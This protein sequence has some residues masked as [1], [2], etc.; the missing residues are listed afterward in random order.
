MLV[1]RLN[2]QLGRLEPGPIAKA[3]RAI[4]LLYARPAIVA[5]HRVIAAADGGNATDAHLLH[6]RFDL[7]DVS[8]PR[9]GRCVAAIGKGMEKN[10][11]HPFPPAQ[12]QTAKEMLEQSM[13]ACIADDAKEMNRAAI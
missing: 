8:E 9:I 4:G 5:V 1:V 2:R 3:N 6:L 10:A 13:H 11:I 12:F 7:P